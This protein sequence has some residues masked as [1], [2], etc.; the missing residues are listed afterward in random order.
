MEGTER[1]AAVDGL[2]QV[3]VDAGGVVEGML[4]GVGVAVVDG[5]VE[6]DVVCGIDFQV[7]GL[8]AVAR[9]GGKEVVE[10]CSG[11]AVGRVDEET[12]GI[13]AVGVVVVGGPHG[14]VERGEAVA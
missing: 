10:E 7:E 11:L 5:V 6:V 8:Q 9:V 4:E 14:E 12:R 1:V 2:Q 13:V 3:G